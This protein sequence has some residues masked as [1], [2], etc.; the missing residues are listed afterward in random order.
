VGSN[1]SATYSNLGGGGSGVNYIGGPS[2][3]L[4]ATTSSLDCTQSGS[5]NLPLYQTP[6]SLV[7]PP[8]P[9][10]LST[11]SSGYF[12][13]SSSSNSI[14]PFPSSH[15][16]SNINS[17]S[18]A[19]SSM[20]GPTASSSSSANQLIYANEMPSA[21]GSAVGGGAIKNS[22]SGPPQATSASGSSDRSDSP[23]Q[24]GVCVQQSPVASH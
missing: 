21:T 24:V 14:Y 13:A 23:M 11:N 19:F 20:N 10:G 15:G 8:G 2:A 3:A 17:S 18:S 7:H 16:S 4:S 22:R 6:Y 1:N 5:L 12:N 9:S